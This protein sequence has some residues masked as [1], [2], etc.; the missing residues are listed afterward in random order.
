MCYG[1]FGILDCDVPYDV[2]GLAQLIQNVKICYQ[3]NQN[4]NY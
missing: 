4:V 2:S 3:I 1:Y